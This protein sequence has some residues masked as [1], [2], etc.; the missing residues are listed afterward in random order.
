M[1]G[2]IGAT[3]DAAATTWQAGQNGM[4]DMNSA[5]VMAISGWNGPKS[6]V[7]RRV[8][9]SE[10]VALRHSSLGEPMTD[11]MITFVMDMTNI[12]YTAVE[13]RALVFQTDDINWCSLYE[14]EWQNDIHHAWGA[15]YSNDMWRKYFIRGAKIAPGRWVYE[16]ALGRP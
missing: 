7:Q 10:R 3:F 6:S 16:V 8:N 5:M 15:F 13:I 4:A 14:P 11:D 12:A 2:C 1:Y 9:V